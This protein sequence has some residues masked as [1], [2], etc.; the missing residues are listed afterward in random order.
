MQEV[1]DQIATVSGSNTSVLITGETGTGKELVAQAIHYNSARATKPFVKVH[2][3]A[4]PESVIESEL[5]GHE[6]GAFTGAI[7]QRKGR[8]ELAHTGTIFLDEVGDVPLLIQIK[9]LRV[10]QEREFERV[11]GSR[12]LKTDV[13]IIAATNKDLSDMTARGGFREDLFYRLNVFPIHVPPLRK[14]KSD[15]VQLADFFLERYAR[16]NGSNVRRPLERRDRHA[17]ELPLARQRPRARELHRT[18]GSRGE[19]RRDPPPT[20]CRRPFR[21]AES[22]GTEPPG[23]FRYLVENYERDLLRDAL[24][25]ARGNIAEASRKLRTTPRITGYKIKKFGIDPNRYAG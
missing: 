22:S 6:R 1:Y 9:M 7:H 2:C 10:L 14:R 3:A 25:S 5:F 12:T 11:G 16:A 15:I 21:P 8:F 17:D 24:K 23:S 19:K 13:R 4:L 20:T 18:R